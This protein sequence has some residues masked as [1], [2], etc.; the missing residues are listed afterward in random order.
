[1]N[2][3]TINR[4]SRTRSTVSEQAVRRAIAA[5]RTVMTEGAATMAP[6][7]EDA[8]VNGRRGTR[9]AGG[10]PQILRRWSVAELI[11]GATRRQA[12]A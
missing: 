6:D 10:H 7:T 2:T 5:R 1:M 8:T 4:P 12:V 3:R 9:A 11:A